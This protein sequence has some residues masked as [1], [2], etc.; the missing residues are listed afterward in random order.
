VLEKEAQ[1]GSRSHKDQIFCICNIQFSD[2]SPTALNYLEN[3]EMWCWRRLDKI[4]WIG[5]V[6]NEDVLRRVNEERNIPN[7]ME[8]KGRLS[9]LGPSCL[10][11]A[12]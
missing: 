4:S 2:F 7:T 10:E 8:K 12:F 11:I 5:H 6:R 3:F 9:G 1:T